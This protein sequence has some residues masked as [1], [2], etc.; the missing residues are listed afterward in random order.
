MPSQGVRENW[1]YGAYI[2]SNL[3]PFTPWVWNVPSHFNIGAA[4]SDRDIGTKNEHT[5]AMI[6][7]DALL[8]TDQISFSELSQRTSQFAQLL[9]EPDVLFGERVL[10]RLPNCLE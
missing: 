2:M 3:V 9:R 10:I 7:E 8:G 4:C 5:T 6:V 1:P